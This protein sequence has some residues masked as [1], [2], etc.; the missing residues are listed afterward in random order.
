MAKSVKLV[1]VIP[2]GPTCVLDYIVDSIHSI[3]HYTTLDRQII[4][5]DDSGKDTG[6]VLQT[7]FPDLDVVKTPENYGKMGGL[8]LSLSMGYLHAH[9]LYDFEA[10]L[11]FD[12]DAL[13]IG[14]RPEEDAAQFFRQHPNVGL[15]GHYHRHVAEDYR[16]RVQIITEGRR[17]N[18]LRNPLLCIALR[19]PLL[20]AL[21]N[22]YD[23]GDFVFG[24]AYFMS[25][26]CVRRLVQAKLLLRKQLRWSKL[27]E[28]HL[29]TLLV[30]S[31]GLEMADFTAGSLPIEVEWNSL[32]CSPRELIA[33]H[34]KITHSTRSWEDMNEDDIRKFFREIRENQTAAAN[35]VN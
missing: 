8:Y 30:S 2:V 1:V 4:I 7:F 13:I 24:A 25:G 33:K 20:K 5:V 18:L 12:T 26:E 9:Q 19:R 34:K 32:P 6:R 23:R 35:R 16:S 15:L 31:V 27:E 28:D 29:F 17:K 21:A 14:D 11:R 3:A 10:L 22:G